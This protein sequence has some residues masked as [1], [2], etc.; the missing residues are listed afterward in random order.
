MSGGFRVLRREQIG[1]QALTTAARPDRM[2]LRCGL[3]LRF[4]AVGVPQITDSAA[5][6]QR[7][8]AVDHF[9]QQCRL[10]TCTAG[11]S[12]LPL[13]TTHMSSL[14]VITRRR[15]GLAAETAGQDEHKRA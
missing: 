1:Q 6:F 11:R 14:P 12:A 7:R 4:G 3:Q 13:A 9:I 2:I 8:R 15:L 10:C 5:A